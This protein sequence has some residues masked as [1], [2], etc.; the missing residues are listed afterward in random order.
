MLRSPKNPLKQ[1]H[2]RLLLS[3]AELLPVFP[4]GPLA[5]SGNIENRIGGLCSGGVLRSLCFGHL[6][7]RCLLHTTDGCNETL[8]ELLRIFRGSRTVM[9]EQVAEQYQ[10]ES[11]V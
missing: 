5:D 9:P 10:E 7:I 8:D 1:L 2:K 4:K 3:R 11:T 6:P